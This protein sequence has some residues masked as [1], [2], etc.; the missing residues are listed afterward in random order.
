[1]STTKDKNKKREYDQTYYY[2]HQKQ[3]LEKS[4]LRKHLKIQ[5]KRK[6]GLKTQS[7]IIMIIGY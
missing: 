1:M 3:I 4:R 5:K 6:Y 7:L 2:K